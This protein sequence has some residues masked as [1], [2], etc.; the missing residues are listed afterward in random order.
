ME[1][2]DSLKSG[3]AS[4]RLAGATH[5]ILSDQ[6]TDFPPEIFAL[7]ESLT[8]LNL[9]NNQLSQLPDSFSKLKHLEI[10]FFNN[11]NFQQFPTVLAECPAL[12]MVSFKG[13]QIEEIVAEAL[14]P[15]LRWLI[16]TNNKIELLPDSIGQLPRLQKL[17]LAGNRLR[18]LPSQLS[19]CHNLELIRLSA[20]QLQHL[21]TWLHEMP[22]LSWMAYAGNPFCQDYQVDT[23]ANDLPAVTAEDITL[24]EQLGQGASGV[25]YKAKWQDKDVAIKLFKGEITSDGSPLDEM[26]A[27]IAAG[28]HPNLV[29]VLARYNSNSQT[30]LVFDFIPAGYRNLGGPPSL[31]SCTRDTYS[32]ETTFTLHEVKQIAADMASAVSHLHKHGIMH[33]DLYAHNI[34]IN[35][36][37]HSILGDFGAASFYELADEGLARSLQQLESRAFGCL[38]EDLL[39]R[40]D[41]TKHPIFSNM[42]L[43]QQRC[44]THEPEKRPC[45]QAISDE[46]LS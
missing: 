28:L 18:A 15:T 25:I 5:L 14:S 38:L 19:Q 34:L 24:G 30:G 20:N 33:G 21:P 43:L 2:L 26:R 44:M 32:E 16:L 46:L 37:G 13:N 11:N 35:Q 45:F 42:R 17:M 27:C 7:A 22:R 3:L 29:N 8:F 41:D 40:C 31:Q 6:L 10:V 36:Q 1:T 23:S 39:D 12:S 9:S 4:G